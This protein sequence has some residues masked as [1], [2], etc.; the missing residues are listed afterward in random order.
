MTK[1]EVKTASAAVKDIL[2]SNPDGLHEVL[3][4]VMQ[5]VLEAEDAGKDG[6]HLF[7]GVNSPGGGRRSTSIPLRR[8]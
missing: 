7:D 8:K 1:T 4:A 2:L 6:T 3:R 5:E